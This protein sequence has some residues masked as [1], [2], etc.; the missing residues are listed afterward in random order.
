MHEKKIK[1]VLTGG[2]TAG[3]VLPHFAMLHLYRE[4]EWDILYIGS[5]G[6]EKQLVT[7]EGLRFR[8]IK[9]GKLRRHLSLQ[10]FF[11]IF[12]VLWGILQSLHIMRQER[13]QIVF[14]KGGYVSV[15]VAIAAWFLKIPVIT[16]ESDLSPGLANRI[17]T[18]FSK[19]ILCAFPETIK[20]LPAIKSQCVGLPVR[21]DINQGNK[22]KAYELCNFRYDDPRPIILI[23]GGSQGAVRINT[24]IE[25]TMT[26]LLES[27]RLI[28]L[29]GKGKTCGVI[30]DGYKEFEFVNDELKH[31]LSICELVICRSGA[32]T[33]FE[34]LSLQKPMLMI[35]LEMASR[36][37]QVENALLF[38][39][40]NWGI[41]LRETTLSPENLLQSL[42]ELRAKTSSIIAAMEKS[43]TNNAAENIF[44]ILMAV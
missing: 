37:D 2:G 10:N 13:P 29:T 33:I 32:N 26:T 21:N 38:A 4:A 40:N 17:I 44:Q 35:P 1:I 24:L 7:K 41:V 31:L 8:E 6:I 5:T 39:K 9:T 27:F 11:D 19:K 16:H 43:P 25:K 12:G 36:G 20:A 34:L 30:K 28:H 18:K 3:H 23:M 42:S 22:N 14:S 15:P